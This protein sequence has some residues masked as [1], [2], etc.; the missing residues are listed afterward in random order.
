MTTERQLERTF[1][2]FPVMVVV[3]AGFGGHKTMPTHSPANCL[4][5]ALFP[6]CTSLF[7]HDIPKP[8]NS[9]KYM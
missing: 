1:C 9:M 5:G 3:V 8:T 7:F 2:V 6:F 4:S